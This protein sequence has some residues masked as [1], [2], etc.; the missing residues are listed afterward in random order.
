VSG[1]RSV[2]NGLYRSHEIGRIQKSWRGQFAVALIYPNTYSIGISNLGFQTVYRLLNEMDDVICERF[3]LPEGDD[4]VRSLESGR[5]LRDFDILA[6]SISFEGDFIHVL[7]IFRAAGIPF[8][9]IQRNPP[10]PLIIAGGVACFLNPEPIAPLIDLFLLGEAEELLPEFVAIARDHALSRQDT[11][12]RL[13]HEVDGAYVPRYYHLSYGKNG[14]IQSMEA[15]FGIPGQV[16]RRYVSHVD[17]F[18]TESQILTPDTTFADRYLIETGRGCVHGCRFCTA[19]Y[20][21]RPPRFRSIEVLE[22]G[23]RQASKLTDRV[24]LVGAAISDLPDL[25]RLCQTAYEI[26]ID[27]SFSSLRADCITTELI[28]FMVKSGVK[29]ATLAPDAGSERMRKVI[30]KGITEYHVLQATESLV[31]NGIPNLKLYFMIGLPTE[32]PDDV[33]AII[34]MVLKTKAVFLKASRIRRKIGEISISINPFIPKAFTPFQWVGM[35]DVQTL[36]EKAGRIVKGLKSISNVRVT[37]ANIRDAVVQAMIARGD[38]RVSDILVLA[39]KH[40][41]NWAR[42]F[43][44]AEISHKFFAFRQRK[45][46]ETLPWDFICHGVSSAFLKQEYQKAL[47]ARQSLPCPIVDCVRCGVCSL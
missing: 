46:T 44:E 21:Y 8:Y 27:L 19:G 35:Q 10:H 18:P 47:K 12:L 30:N 31:Y 38:R 4:P 1:N 5:P 13:A 11:L 36:K 43:K 23:L 9:S 25:G 20:I 7:S 6:F 16:R 32:T 15:R 39:E 40:R 26:G 33:D 24:G 45:L 29:T 2:S 34:D 3:F 42:T 37:V 14:T 28:Q 41:W 17:D 22:N